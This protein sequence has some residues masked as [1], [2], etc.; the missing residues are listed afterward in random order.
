MDTPHGNRSMF[1]VE[2]LRDPVSIMNVPLPTLKSKRMDWTLRVLHAQIQM[3]KNTVCFL[4]SRHVL[5]TYVNIEGR[6]DSYL[7]FKVE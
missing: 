7:T 3:K 2:V 4:V 6:I 5:I 1:S